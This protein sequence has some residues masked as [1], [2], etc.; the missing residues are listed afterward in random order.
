VTV[1]PRFKSDNNFFFSDNCFTC[2][3][4]HRGTGPEHMASR[5]GLGIKKHSELIV[6]LKFATCYN[7]YTENN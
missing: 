5:A 4:H 3:K 1:R 6:E 2:V 7:Q